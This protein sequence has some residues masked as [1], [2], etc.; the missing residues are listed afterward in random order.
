MKLLEKRLKQEFMKVLVFPNMDD[1]VI[2]FMNH[3]PYSI[4]N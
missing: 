3:V 1:E 2:P 4:T